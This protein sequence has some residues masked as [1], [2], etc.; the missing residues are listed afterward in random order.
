MQF[1]KTQTALR[2]RLLTLLHTFHATHI[3]S[4][5]STID[6]I[7]AVYTVKK[8]HEK[9][10]LSSGHAAVAL[11]VVLEKYGYLKNADLNKLHIHPDR[12]E[13][14]G[15]DLST[16]S[17]GQG[18]PIATGM[19]LADSKKNVY[20]L[21]SD[22]ECAEGSIWETLRVISEQK[23]LNIKI[24]VS[25]NGWGAYDPID[26]KNLEKRFK[27]FGFTVLK[28]DGH[29]EE[30]I[31]SALRMKYAKPTILFAKTISD[32]FPFLVGQDAH[33]HTMNDNDYQS[34]NKKLK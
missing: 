27:G 29:N 25:V 18:L 26:A 22:G 20:C 14:R 17:L 1:T 21:M 12:D 28:I 9:F 5:L 4:C 15:I 7:D 10:I 23:I 6:I 24:I 33:Y 2:Q 3:G 16:G 19:A 30:K 31:V 34:A 13:K 11:Y 32:Q 8:R